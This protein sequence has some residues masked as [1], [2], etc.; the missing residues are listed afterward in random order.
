MKK[1]FILAGF[2]FV[3]SCAFAMVD[4]PENREKE[5]KRYLQATPPKAMFEDMAEKVAY[6]LPPEKRE[7]FKSL[8][9]R[10][11]DIEALTELMTTAMVNNFT[12]DELGALAD[13]YGSE[14]GKSSVAKFGAY[15]ADVMPGLQAEM[16]KAQTKAN[17]ELQDLEKKSDPTN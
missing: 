5:A 2:L 8:L 12:A 11:L 1:I 10:H 13:F 7:E 3:A 16:I 4:S 6:N 9:T 14:V 17:R 15:M